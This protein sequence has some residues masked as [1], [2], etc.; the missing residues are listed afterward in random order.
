MPACVS[1]HQRT[2][3]R[4]MMTLFHSMNKLTNDRIV[5]ELL[6][7][8]Y[9]CMV[10]AQE[11][12]VHRGDN[13]PR[14][15]RI[16]GFSRIVHLG[17]FWHV[18]VQALLL[19]PVDLCSSHMAGVVS[20]MAH[21]T[22]MCVCIELCAWTVC[23]I[24]YRARLRSRV[25]SLLWR[26]WQCFNMTH[27]TYMMMMV[28]VVWVQSVRKTQRRATYKGMSIEKTEPGSSSDEAFITFR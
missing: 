20:G 27:I 12:R 7:A 22:W 9:D 21:G 23:H 5:S 10:C 25:S 24:K 11:C 2:S 3:T 8:V 18:F 1:V 4:A 26:L 14:Q 6:S 13:S 19:S 28:Y 15:R 16:S 17:G